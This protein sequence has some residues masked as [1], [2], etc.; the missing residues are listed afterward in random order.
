M[1]GD[2]KIRYFKS[3][4][5][6]YSVHCVESGLE[7]VLE[8]LNLSE[9][10]TGQKERKKMRHRSLYVYTFNNAQCTVILI[11]VLCLNLSDAWLH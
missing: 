6:G 10:L 7:T 8:Q 2:V 1:Y 4:V 3:A 11:H 9:T 5:V